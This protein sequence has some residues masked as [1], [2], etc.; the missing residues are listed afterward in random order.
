MPY[1]GGAICSSIVG[2]GAADGID[3]APA[4]PCDQRGRWGLGGGG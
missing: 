3:T 4:D 1:S 2:D